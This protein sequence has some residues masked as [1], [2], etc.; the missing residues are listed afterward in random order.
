MDDQHPYRVT[1][2][3]MSANSQRP[4]WSVMIPTYNC[5]GYLRETLAG[6]L[7][8]DPGEALMQIEVVDDCSTRDDP[9]AVVA[10]LGC[11][12][13]GFYRQ[14]HNVGHVANFN[15]CLQRAR[16]ELVHL[17]HGDDGVRDG[18]YRTM[19]RAFDENPRI[20]NAFCRH[21]IMDE[22]GHWQTISPLERLE[23][24]P[25]SN[26]LEE[27]AVGQR[28][29]APSMVVRRDVYE[30][31]GGF[32]RR[33]HFYGEDWEMWVRIA[34]FYPVWYETMPLAV[35]RIHKVSLSGR[36]QRT[37]EN[38]QD[39]RRAIEINENCLPRTRAVDLSRQARENCALAAIRRASRMEMDDLLVALAQVREAFRCGHSLRVIGAAISLF[40]LSAWRAIRLAASL[41]REKTQ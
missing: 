31:L 22:Y 23:S 2:P 36:S 16:G 20:G 3:P 30:R 18:F 26:W 17:L 15:T 12:R 32:D 37:G 28:L 4:R 8:Q 14:P 7:A 41:L 39:L 1:I 13:V 40:V 11:G 24:G 10:Q 35:Y 6:V 9:E 38:M 21:I 33:L 5:A 27:I 29:Q 34:A 19:Q 25:L